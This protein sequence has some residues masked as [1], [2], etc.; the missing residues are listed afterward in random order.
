VWSGDGT[1]H[2]RGERSLPGEG[3]RR[4]GGSVAERLWRSNGGELPWGSAAAR[5]APAAS[6]E[7]ERREGHLHLEEHQ[8]MTVHTVNGG[9][10]VAWWCEDSDDGGGPIARRGHEDE[11][12]RGKGV[13]LEQSAKERNRGGE[14]GRDNDGTTPF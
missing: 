5:G 14:K 7:R 1:E 10:S 12:E 2:D 9:K 13:A 4:C 3:Y 8:A 11:G 6:H